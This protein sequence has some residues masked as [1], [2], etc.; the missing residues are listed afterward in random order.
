MAEEHLIVEVRTGK[1]RSMILLTNEGIWIPTPDR[2]RARAAPDL[3]KMMLGSALGPKRET[4]KIGD[5]DL[6]EIIEQTDPREAK[7]RLESVATK[8]P[9]SMILR[10]YLARAGRYRRPKLAFESFDERSGGVVSR[11][12]RLAPECVDGIEKML[13]SLIPD[14]LEI[15]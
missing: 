14:R 1:G 5:A 6:G 4:T 13:S 7:R 3:A 8:V 11:E 2:L 15:H 12:F 9:Y 10:C